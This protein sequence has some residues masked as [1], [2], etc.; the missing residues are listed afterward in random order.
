MPINQG[1]SKT[2]GWLIT[3]LHRIEEQHR[4]YKNRI[5]VGVEEKKKTQGTRRDLGHK[6]CGPSPHLLFSFSHHFGWC[7]FLG[8]RKLDE[9][10]N[11]DVGDAYFLVNYFAV[12]KNGTGTLI[13]QNI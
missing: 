10:G 7:A 6:G 12:R 13:F 3:L 4:V 1:L 5:K 9:K 8:G 11:W 2:T